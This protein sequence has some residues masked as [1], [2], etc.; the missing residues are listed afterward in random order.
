MKPFSD[1][2]S[3]YIDRVG[4]SDA[5]LARR[6]G[7]SRQTVFR[8]REGSTSG[9]RHRPDVLRLAE[10]LRLTPEERDQLLLAA[11]FRPEGGAGKP[12]AADRLAV[13]ASAASTQTP[14]NAAAA[15]TPPGVQL[16]WI[17][18]VVALLAFGILA[19]TGMWGA[20]GR[21]IGVD[22]RSSF[23]EPAA[24]GESLVLV[25]EFVNYSGG[26]IGFNVA[27][28]LAEALQDEFTAAGVERTRIEVLNRPFTGA[29]QARIVAEDLGAEYVLWGE[30]DSGRVIA[31][32]TGPGP[33]E[34]SLADEERWLISSLEQLSA[35][36]NV[37]LPQEVRWMGLYGLG[38]AH[39][40][41]GRDAEAETAF[42][43][44]LENPPSDPSTVAGVY[45]ALGV[46]EGRSQDPDLDRAIALYAEALES[47]P[48]LVS[49]LN[50]RGASYLRRSAVGDLDRAEADF[51]RAMG[52]APDFAPAPFN[53]A[54]AIS[55]RDA[56]DLEQMIELLQRAEAL[57]PE[58]AHLQNA[59]CWYL[60]LDGE[61]ELGLP[62]C[63][64][65][66]ELDS[67]GYS[68]D[69]YGLA[70]ALVGRYEQAA[71][72]FAFFLEKLE[73][74]DREAY[75]A[76]HPSRSAWIESLNVQVNPFDAGALEALLTGET[77]P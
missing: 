43:R 35:T 46:I 75:R 69:S 70:L 11:G 62:H 14:P 71:A 51:R 72:E 33:I 32:L 59:L 48:G 53:L 77:S 5:E 2:L 20:A 4:I 26:G 1:L 47:S 34:S 65:A 66:I 56:P 40:R 58:N 22:L 17:A 24:P 68:N 21:L 54:L 52:M 61:P 30:Y 38:L 60:S 25:A 74:Q 76:F 44:A 9:P 29:E 6:L 42:R 49:A 36:I 16:R 37:Q 63:E 57:D 73:A 12:D 18:P 50:N 27:D 45:F 55:Q 28:R 10:G 19:A 15:P 23:P 41:A 13:A 3:K 64:L 7:V 39:F 8:W 67:S 31:H